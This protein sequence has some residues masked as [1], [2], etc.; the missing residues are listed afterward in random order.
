MLE[1]DRLLLRRWQDSD[2]EPFAAIN[3]DPRVMEFFPSTL[4]REESDQLIDSIESHFDNRGFGLFATENKADHALIG[5]IGLHVASFQA[6]F[7]PCVEIG[8]RIAAPYWGKGLATEGSREVIRFAFEW[9]K[10]ESLVSF[11]VPENIASR[12]LMEKLGMTH[13]PKD[14]F[15]HPRLPPGHRLRRHVLYRLKN[16]AISKS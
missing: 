16:P 6:H 15:D 7:T 11:T 9:L 12:R 2:R 14:D 5:F 4:T 10:L 3:A 13:D 1:T 8:W